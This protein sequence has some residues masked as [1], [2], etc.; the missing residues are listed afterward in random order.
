MCI[1]DRFRNSIHLEYVLEEEIHDDIGNVDDEARNWKTKVD[2]K[3]HEDQCRNCLFVVVSVELKYGGKGREEK[4]DDEE[5]IAEVAYDFPDSV[6]CF[7]IHDLIENGCICSIVEHSCGDTRKISKC[8]KYY[9]ESWIDPLFHDIICCC[10]MNIWYE[11]K[12]CYEEREKKDI[13]R[14]RVAQKS[15]PK[16]IF[17]F[18]DLFHK[19]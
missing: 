8:L 6:Y 2:Q 11:K 5:N 9:I 10:W 16:E 4:D 17:C 1:R 19:K 18:D 3:C 15:S 7:A 14:S 13:A 12:G